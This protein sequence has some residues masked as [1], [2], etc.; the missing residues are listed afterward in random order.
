[1]KIFSAMVIAALLTIG[2]NAC[3]AAE[4]D[5]QRQIIVKKHGGVSLGIVVSTADEEALKDANLKGGA[6]I[7]EV[8]E[9]SEAKRIGLQKGDVITQFD[10][11]KIE[12]AD[13]L[14]KAVGEV[15]EEKKAD[16]VIYRDGKEMKMTAT[17]KPSDK[18]TAITVNADDEDVHIDIDE[19]FDIGFHY[20]F[21]SDDLAPFMDGKGS[22]LG[23][24]ATDISKQLLEYFEVEHGVLLEEVV[25]DSPAEK[26]G[27]KAGDVIQKINDKKIEDFSDLRRA[28]NYYDPGDKV[29]LEYVRKGKKNS[30]TIE[31][32]KSEG[33]VIK[34]FHKLRRDDAPELFRDQKRKSR[35]LKRIFEPPEPPLPDMKWKMDK[36]ELEIFVL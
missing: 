33:K 5:N 14:R 18:E 19:D 31:L 29:K 22:F 35:V 3:R 20:Q 34:K 7:L 25:K 36:D 16:L 8:V 15:K 2:S 10:S 9:D 4:S 1:M 23:V 27:L 12:S 24:E 13:D 17:L 26:A 30:A 28:L 6:K 21:F 11:R 32:G